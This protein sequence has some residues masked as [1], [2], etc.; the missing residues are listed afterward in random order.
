MK[1]AIS[2]PNFGPFGDA[3]VLADLARD[4]EDAGWDGFF[5][6]DHVLWTEPQNQPIVEPWIALAAIAMATSRIRLAPLISPLPRRRPWQVARQAA[7]LDQLSAG[8]LTLGAGI[9]TN[10]FGDYT[11]FGEITDPKAHGQMLDE[12]LDILNGLWSGETFQHTGTHYTV[13]ATCFLPRPRQRP[14]I[15][16]WVAG[17][18]PGTKPFRRAAKW[19]GIVPLRR[20]PGGPL[21]P[22]EYLAMLS[23]IETHGDA[24]STID[25]VASFGVTHPSAAEVA[26]YADAGVTWWKVGFNAENT[27][28]QARDEILLGPP[29]YS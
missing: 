23:Y 24:E 13:E 6:W 29:P 22:D 27:A 16:I 21:E 26:P 25:V 3:R 19:D 18:W 1:Y 15:P 2:V 12:A 17:L 5:I 4:A 7:T 20:G 11:N 14:R 28:Q 8:R 10:R 9:G